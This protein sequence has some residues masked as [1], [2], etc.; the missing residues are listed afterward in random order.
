MAEPGGTHWCAVC[1]ASCAEHTRQCSDR[2]WRCESCY[3][4]WA[5]AALEQAAIY[6]V[7]AENAIAD[8]QAALSA[9]RVA[10]GVDSR[11]VV[12]SE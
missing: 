7:F 9:P 5:E 6:R 3:C 12:Y 8:L 11:E 2:E 1:E 10:I 4:E